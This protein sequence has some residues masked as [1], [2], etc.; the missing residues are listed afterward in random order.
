MPGLFLA[1]GMNTAAGNDGDMGTFA[2]VEIVVDQIVDITV[3]YTGRNVNRFVLGLRRNMDHKTGSPFFGFNL[4]VFGGL[5][6]GAGPILADIVCAVEYPFPV[7]NKPQQRL[8]NFIHT[9]DLLPA[10]SG[11]FFRPPAAWEE[12]VPAARQTEPLH[13]R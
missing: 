4:N 5:P 6:S 8:G 7:G 9:A 13:Q 12:S 3:S 10:G 1:V 11:P 2:H